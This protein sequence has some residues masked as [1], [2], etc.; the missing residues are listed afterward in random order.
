[1]MQLLDQYFKPSG[2]NFFDKIK[3]TML[4]DDYLQ[5]SLFPQKKEMVHGESKQIMNEIN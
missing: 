1:M 3:F 5:I 4:S 2:L